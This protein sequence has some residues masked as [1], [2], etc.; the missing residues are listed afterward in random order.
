MYLIRI[1]SNKFK[2]FEILKGKS[3]HSHFSRLQPHLLL[4]I[5][6]L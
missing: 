4:C 1:L 6:A 3:E 5:G 2:I